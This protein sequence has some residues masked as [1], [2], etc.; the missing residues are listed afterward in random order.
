VHAIISQIS[1]HVDVNIVYAE[2]RPSY[3]FFVLKKKKKVPSYFSFLS[4]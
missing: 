4:G 1:G 3:F 2:S